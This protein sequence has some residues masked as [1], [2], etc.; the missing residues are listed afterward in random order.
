MQLCISVYKYTT[1]NPGV[2]VLLCIYVPMHI[3]VSV[4]YG[5]G[6][7]EDECVNTSKELTIVPSTY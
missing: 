1:V 7:C 3:A 2:L 4:A 5:E 6:Q